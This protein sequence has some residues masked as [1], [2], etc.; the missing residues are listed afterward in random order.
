MRKIF[1]LLL[2]LLLVTTISSS[3]YHVAIEDVVYAQ[4]YFQ[5]MEEQPLNSFNNQPLNSFNNQPLNS[6]NNQPLNSFNNQPPQVELS[7]PQQTPIRK[8]LWTSASWSN[9]NERILQSDQKDP[10]DSQFRRGSQGD[11]IWTIDGNG[12]A[13]I[14]QGGVQEHIY[15]P[16]TK[17][18]N[19]LFLSSQTKV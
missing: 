7:S 13:I 14:E 9:D 11:R 19:S 10:Y 16:K 8:I 1:S 15:L 4:L 6:F 3:V 2:T 18:C 5:P 17:M 12:N